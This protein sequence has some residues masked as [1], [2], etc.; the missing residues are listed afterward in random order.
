MD[1]TTNF[2]AL[3]VE[4][5]LSLGALYTEYLRAEGAR[6]T[7]VN[8]GADAL[9]ELESWQ[10]DLLVLDIKLPDMS[11]MDIL[12]QAQQR[13]PDTIVVMITAH[14][15]IDIAVD[16][17]RLGAF[18]FLVKPFDAKRLS[19]TV[20]NAMK[21]RQLVSLV[22][23]YER[24]LPKANY[25]GFI[26]DSLAMQTVYKTID[27]VANS[28]ASVFIVGESGTGKE[29]CAHAIHHAGQ[30][31]DKPFI[32]L[33][34]ASIP[35]DLIESEIFGHTKGAFTGAVAN[36]DGA[37]SRAH[38]GTLFLDEICEMD[39]ELQ[40][41]LLRFI[42]TG[43][44]QKVGGTKEES[45]DVRF[46]SATNRA[47]WEEV[48]LGRFREDLFYRL[49]VIPIELPPLK[50]RGNDV[51]LLAEKLLMEYSNEEGKA[52]KSF[53]DEVKQVLLRYDWPGNVRQLQN[54]IR[55]MVVLN[56]G[57]V[58]ELSMLPVQLSQS[59]HSAKVPAHVSAIS[60]TAQVTMSEP[61][62]GNHQLAD[63]CTTD[64]PAGEIIPLWMSEKRT[65]EAAIAS[66][67]G[68]VP[69][70]AALLDI[71]ASTI[72]RKRQSWEEMEQASLES[73]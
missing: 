28:K 45:V 33:N 4:D 61:Q 32:A 68:N 60:A 67:D 10:P 70:A 39:L 8:H 65:I 26:G 62:A 20:R 31:K 71:S 35:K 40:S 5:S 16:A 3:L 57:E 12:Q 42:Q 9:A 51:L 44:F 37:A 59:S 24:S 58:V 48:K 50:A 63:N 43:V 73:V 18:D 72:Y 55:Q 47:P 54:T 69:K 29:V 19:I 53:S 23:N 38:G 13:Y 64:E 52:F 21:Q 66:C 27:C 41:K 34:C 1:K 2:T 25:M 46:V 56:Q 14:G 36:R 49:H 6:V 22:T 15:S 7:Q 17:M 11:G 30:R